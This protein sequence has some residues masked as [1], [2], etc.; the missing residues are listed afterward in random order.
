MD[1]VHDSSPTYSSS[2]RSV[3]ILSPFTPRFS[4]V[5]SSFFQ[6]VF[7]SLFNSRLPCY[8]SHSSH[9]S[10]SQMAKRQTEDERTL[11]QAPLYRVIILYDN[12]RCFLPTGVQQQLDIN[13]ITTMLIIQIFW[14]MT[15]C[16]LV[17]IPFQTSVLLP[18]SE[19]NTT[20]IHKHYY[21][22]TKPFE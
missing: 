10:L 20:L 1:T 8:M 14:G 11:G 16:G 22:Y 9:H 21:P 18:S 19:Q 3:L 5:I 4:Q 13:F 2:L 6:P 7:C 17:Q 12:C 15:P